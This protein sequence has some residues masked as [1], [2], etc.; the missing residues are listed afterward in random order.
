MLSKVNTM[1]YKIHT[2]TLALS[3]EIIGINY[4]LN[5]VYI[6]DI[7]RYLYYKAFLRKTLFIIERRCYIIF[8]MTSI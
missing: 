3:I 2:Y 5:C 7:I 8:Y 4:C 1:K 6:H